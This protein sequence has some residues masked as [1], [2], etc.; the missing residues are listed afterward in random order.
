LS[1]SMDRTSKGRLAFIWRKASR[2]VASPFP[3]TER[4]STQV[5]AISVRFV[6]ELGDGVLA[7]ITRRGAEFV[8]DLGLH[9][10]GRSTIALPHRFFEG[11]AHS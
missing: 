10:F 5:E 1:E 4:V 2:I 6:V 7:V 3:R 8:Q 11:F 9:R